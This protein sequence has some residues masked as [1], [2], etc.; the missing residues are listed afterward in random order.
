MKS[1][2]LILYHI[3]AETGAPFSNRQIHNPKVQDGVFRC[4]GIKN[5]SPLYFSSAWHQADGPLNRN[6]SLF[7]LWMASSLEI[8]MEDTKEKTFGDIRRRRPH[9]PN[10]CA[11]HLSY[12][13]QTACQQPDASYWRAWWCR[14]Q[15]PIFS[16]ASTVVFQCFRLLEKAIATIHDLSRWWCRHLHRNGIKALKQ[17]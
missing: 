17:I 4:I 11:L 15:P 13:D 12:R 3:N 5:V 14:T 2:D 9:G 8:T 1:I 10:G 6:K 16:I 7:C